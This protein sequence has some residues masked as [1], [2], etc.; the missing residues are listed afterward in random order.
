MGGDMLDQR[1][2]NVCLLDP[3]NECILSTLRYTLLEQ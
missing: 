1:H 3:K 2:E